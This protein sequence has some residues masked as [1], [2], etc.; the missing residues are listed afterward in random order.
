MYRA[1][2]TCR[3]RGFEVTRVHDACATVTRE[4]QRA[5]VTTMKDRYACTLSTQQVLQ[6]VSEVV[7]EHH[8]TG[9]MPDPGEGSQ[10]S[11]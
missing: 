4:L 9:H 1:A 5:T 3:A 2:A 11:L 8:G 10:A 6:R 7:S